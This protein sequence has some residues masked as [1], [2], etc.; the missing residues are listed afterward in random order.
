MVSQKVYDLCH[1]QKTVSSELAHD[2]SLAPGSVAKKLYGEDVG[3]HD[4]HKHFKLLDATEQDLQ[5]A[6][7]SGKWGTTRPSDLFL[8]VGRGHLLIHFP[9]S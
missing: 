9:G 6:Y 8:K 2:P 4:E 1:G 3:G 7:E 5:K